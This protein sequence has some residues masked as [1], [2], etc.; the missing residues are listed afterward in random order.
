MAQKKT[1]NE[2][3]NVTVLL[4]LLSSYIYPKI[5]RKNPGSGSIQ[6]EEEVQ[7]QPSTLPDVLIDLL[8]TSALFISIAGYL[9]NDSGGWIGYS[10][11]INNISTINY[12]CVLSVLDMSRHVP[13]YKAILEFLRSLVSSPQLLPLLAPW[14]RKSFKSGSGDDQC[15]SVLLTKMKEVVDNYSKRLT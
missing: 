5:S 7:T 9:R 8:R 10:H 4:H 11:L 12:S 3:E 6:L 13:L 1:Q 2:E 15:I 14:E